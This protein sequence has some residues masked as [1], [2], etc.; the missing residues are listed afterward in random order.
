MKK[1]LFL[2]TVNVFIF[3]V[4]VFAEPMIFSWNPVTTHTDG[5]PVGAVIYKVYK[6]RIGGPYLF[7]ASRISTTYTWAEPQLGEWVFTIRAFNKNGES[8]D[9]ATVHVIVNSC[10]EEIKDSPP[11]ANSVKIN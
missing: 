9:S 5:T 11:G 6:K 3:A 7:L 10:W 4:N 8:I 2:I 1:I